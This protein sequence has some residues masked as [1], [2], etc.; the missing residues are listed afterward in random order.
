MKII[1][2]SRD[3]FS[4]NVYPGDPFPRARWTKTID[5][6]N[7]Y[8]LSEFSSGAHNATHVDAPFHYLPKGATVDKMPLECFIGEC[9]VV[10]TGGAVTGSEIEEILEYSK[11]RL[12]LRSKGY[13]Y[14]TQ[15]AAFE[16]ASSKK[17]VLVGTDSMSIADERDE[18]EVHR[19]LMMENIA[20]IEGLNLDGVFDG[21]YY[22][23]AAPV[24]FNGM[25]AAPVR[26]ILVKQD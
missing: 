19:E 18:A 13:A 14:L 5:D 17:I 21:D 2:I 22:L 3:Y 1:D 25:E 6:E 20:I 26:A 4:T 23:Y 11:P 16:L 9:T 24:K 7:A 8:R 10:T 15:S 12:L